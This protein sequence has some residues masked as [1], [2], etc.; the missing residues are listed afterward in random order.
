[1]NMH[2]TFQIE[3]MKAAVTGIAWRRLVTK[4]GVSTTREAPAGKQWQRRAGRQG[5]YILH[6]TKGWRFVSDKRLGVPA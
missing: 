4:H 2:Q 6:A 5:Y 3:M 1:M